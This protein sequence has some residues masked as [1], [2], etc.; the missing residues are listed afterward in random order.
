MYNQTATTQRETA[1]SMSTIKKS[2]TTNLTSFKCHV[3]PL[4]AEVFQDVPGGFGKNWLM[5]CPVLD[6]KEGDKVTVDGTTDYRVTG[7]ENYN[8]SRNPHLEV[9]IRA[10]R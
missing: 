7:V 9:T 10:F 1:V 2:Y 5:F 3:Q 8:F 4:D 6:I